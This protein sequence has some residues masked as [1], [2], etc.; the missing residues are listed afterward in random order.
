MAK[1]SVTSNEFDKVLASF[2]S[3]ADRAQLKRELFGLKDL[4]EMLKEEQLYKGN[5]LW[6]LI[7][8]VVIGDNRNESALFVSV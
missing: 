1:S 8:S 7:V 6:P 2:V 4:C 3:S 5:V